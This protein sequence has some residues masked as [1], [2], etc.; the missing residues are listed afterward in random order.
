MKGRD[1]IKATVIRTTTEKQNLHS[2][3]LV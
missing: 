3:D 2:S 1:Q